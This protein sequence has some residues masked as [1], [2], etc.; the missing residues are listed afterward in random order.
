MKASLVSLFHAHPKF[1]AMYVITVTE[2]ADFLLV[3]NTSIYAALYIKNIIGETRD[4]TAF[5][6][7]LSPPFLF[8]FFNLLFYLGMLQAQLLMSAL[9]AL[10]V[11]KTVDVVCA[12]TICCLCSLGS[13]AKESTLLKC[14]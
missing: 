4:A 2:C 5:F 8:S 12:W 13:D 7:P 6:F 14:S 10:I 1:Y 11:K 9:T 3:Y